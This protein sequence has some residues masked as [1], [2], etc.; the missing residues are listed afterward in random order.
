MK[1]LK[2]L[3]VLCVLSIFTSCAGLSNDPENIDTVIITC[4]LKESRALAE[5]LQYRNRQLIMLLPSNSADN[6]IYVSGPENQIMHIDE[7]KFSSFIDFIDPKNVIVLGNEVY[8]PK[9]YTSRIHPSIRSYNFDDKDWQLIAWQL[10]E[11][12]GLDGLAE[13]YINTLDRCIRAG[14]V[15]SRYA[16]SY[17][18]EPQAIQPL[19]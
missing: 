4:N 6:K 5:H 2:S 17:P 16:P 9:S 19:K 11:L 14:L 13:D 1:C 18:S 10:E 3:L 15:K 8:V 12:T 7:S